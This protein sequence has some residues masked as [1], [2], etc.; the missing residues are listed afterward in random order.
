[1]DKS[2][3]IAWLRQLPDKAFFEV[4]YESAAGRGP[5]EHDRAWRE[6]HVVV[7][8]AVRETED[9]TRSNRWSSE[10][11][12]LPRDSRSSHGVDNAIL[13]ESAE[14]CGHVLISWAKEICCPLCGSE[15]H[16]T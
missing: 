3:V 16:A 15:L 6:A 12:A 7:G 1:M 4:V 13:C 11:V 14:H 5:D 2:E 9:G 10:L 8:F